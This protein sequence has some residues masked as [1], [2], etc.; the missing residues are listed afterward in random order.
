MSRSWIW[1]RK[2]QFDQVLADSNEAIRLD[3]KLAMAYSDRGAAWIVKQD[4]DKAL[5]DLNQAI[6]LDP[7]NAMA[8]TNRAP[9][10]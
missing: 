2:G 8:Y 10:G 1:G 3:P 7:R 6:R 9:P 4:P 5:V